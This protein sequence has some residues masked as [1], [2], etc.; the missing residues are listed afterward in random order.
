MIH[1]RREKDKL[2]EKVL[3]AGPFVGEFGMELFSWQGYVRALSKQ[4][5]KTIVA[6]RPS[7]EFIYKDF[8]DEFIPFD[9]GSNNADGYNCFSPITIPNIHD[10]YNPTK[11]F[12][13][14]TQQE[15]S[16]ITSGLEQ[17]FVSYQT[18]KSDKFNID[19]CVC[20]RNFKEGA[21]TKIQ[22]NWDIGECEKTVVML[23]ENGYSVGSVG[24]KCSAS[25]INGTENFMDISLKDMSTLLSSCKVI[26]GPSSG[27]MHF[28]SLCKCAQIV[29]G[30]LNLEKRYRVDW[31]PF[32]SS[33]IYIPKEEYNITSNEIINVIGGFIK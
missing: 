24:L 17:N 19:I 1:K 11:V 21:A 7:N 29:W 25:Y 26:I 9:P 3:F 6:S 2:S 33:V 20:A 22:R 32:S 12:T 14:T 27:I 8:C 13:A 31:N 15:H 16:K 18:D 30:E 23:K 28:A 4:F 5:D 10:K